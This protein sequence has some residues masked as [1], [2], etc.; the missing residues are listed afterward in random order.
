MSLA[1][2]DS[3]EDD[4]NNSGWAPAAGPGP[5][6]APPPAPG[7]LAPAPGPAP[8]VAPTTIRRQDRLLQLTQRA[9]VAQAEARLQVQAPKYRGP[10]L[11]SL[12]SL[13]LGVLG[14]YVQVRA[15][16][17]VTKQYSMNC[18]SLWR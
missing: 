8:P 1:W 17:V 9:G 3:D 16:E 13:C 11:H 5:A 7:P 2:D 10:P 18:G 14:R 12:H 15:A 6:P 4:G